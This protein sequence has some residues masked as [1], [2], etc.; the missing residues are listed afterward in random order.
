MPRK[1]PRPL[2][3]ANDATDLALLVMG[4]REEPVPEKFAL[5]AKMARSALGEKPPWV[6]VDDAGPEPSF[7]AVDFA[8]NEP[9]LIRGYLHRSTSGLVIGRVGIEHFRFERHLD[10]FVRSDSDVEVTGLVLRKIRLGRIR[11]R[12]LLRFRRREPVYA[13]ME[14]GGW[15]SPDDY[16][17][18]RELAELSRN[19]PR[20]RGR[21]GYPDDHYRRI[22]FA[23][24]DDIKEH[25]NSRGVLDRLAKAE[26]VQRSTIRDW[27]K[28]AR[29]LEFLAPT[30]QG[31][32]AALAGP[33][34]LPK[35]QK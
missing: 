9:W 19:Q 1:T 20:K 22:A 29:E 17:R 12:A 13:S 23:Y 27:V 30:K 5:R 4:W 35:E 2:P 33:N 28:R 3:D 7:V 6:D 26:H 8:A 14:R 34:L 16:G 31:R 25:G 10:L 18:A 32:A 11:D 24:I 15:I 21:A